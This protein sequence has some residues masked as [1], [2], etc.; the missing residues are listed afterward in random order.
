MRPST[1]TRRGRPRAPETE[2][3]TLSVG[4]PTSVG[5]V[6]VQVG[7]TRFNVIAGSRV[8]HSRLPNNQPICYVLFGRDLQ[9]LV[10]EGEI[11][12][13]PHELGELLAQRVFG[14]SFPLRVVGGRTRT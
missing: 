9:I 12:D 7:R 1:K 5:R 14:V 2:I 13:V 10:P 4:S 8:A 6:P 3:V 11:L